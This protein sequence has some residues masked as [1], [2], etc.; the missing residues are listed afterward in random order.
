M[1]HWA[2]FSVIALIIFNVSSLHPTRKDWLKLIVVR[3]WFPEWSSDLPSQF[4]TLTRLS[5]M[6]ICVSSQLLTPVPPHY[7]V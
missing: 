2:M 1:L 7:T 6:S 3:I 4:V 5:A